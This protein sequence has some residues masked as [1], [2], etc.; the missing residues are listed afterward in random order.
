[1]LS[2]SFT[3]PRAVATV[4]GLALLASACGGASTETGGAA[5][6][7]TANGTPDAASTAEVNQANLAT[8]DDV[9]DIEVLSVDDGSISSLRDA[10]DGDRPVL[11]WFWA[12][13]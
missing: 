10:V 13:H 9:R 8:S 2:S 11:L 5:S 6:S 4:V 3:R 1:M 7:G 12:P